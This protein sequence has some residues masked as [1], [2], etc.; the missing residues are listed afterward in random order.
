MELLFKE[1]QELMQL[2][3]EQV[4]KLNSLLPN[5]YSSCEIEEHSPESYFDI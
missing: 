5:D 4:K 2:F 3:D 1:Y